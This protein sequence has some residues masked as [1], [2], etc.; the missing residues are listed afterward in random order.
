MQPQGH[1]TIT[2]QQRIAELID[3]DAAA[4]GIYQRHGIAAVEAWPTFVR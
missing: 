4:F 3:S 1:P 2:G